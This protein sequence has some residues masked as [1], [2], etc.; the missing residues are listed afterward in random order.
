MVIKIKL[1]AFR[2][3]LY[4]VIL[5]SKGNI[6]RETK[7][8]KNKETF[9]VNRRKYTF[10]NY[11]NATIY[12]RKGFFF[13]KYYLF[14]NVNSIKPLCF[15]YNTVTEDKKIFPDTELINTIL[16]ADTVKKLND[17]SKPNWLANIDPKMI[18][19]GLIA[20]VVMIYFLQG[21]T[22]T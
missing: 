10:K 2:T 17:L 12:Y 19:I 13:H 14:Y 15:D 9:S 4:A 16:E 22:L 18:V 1:N 3:Q 5:D 21:G 8:D 6:Q 20:V 7:L 11:E